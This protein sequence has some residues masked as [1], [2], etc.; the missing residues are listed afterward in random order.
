MSQANTPLSLMPS[1]K[2]ILVGIGL[3]LAFV[4]VMGFVF[5][6]ESEA[7][8]K[9][10]VEAYGLWGLWLGV[11]VTDGIPT[12]GGA[13]PLMTICLQGGAHWVAIG[14]TCLAA[15]CGAGVIGYCL[16][17]MMGIPTA[18]GEWMDRKFPGKV[19]YLEEKGAI[20]VAAL[21]ALPIPITLGTWLGGAFKVKP[22]AV[23]LA[24][25][26]RLPKVVIFLWVIMG[27]LKAVS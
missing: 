4:M 8:G 26:V 7:F 17:R 15:S 24:V 10:F 21:A 23:L 27:G 14:A 16:G 13:I 11:L 1:T 9:A 3:C 20:G 25:A 18:L 22:W 19:E 6:D 2:S 5:K 12:P